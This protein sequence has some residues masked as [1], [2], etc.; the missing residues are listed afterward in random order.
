MTPGRLIG[1]ADDDD[2]LAPFG[3]GD[4]DDVGQIIFAGRIVVADLAEPA[5]QVGGAHRHHPRIAQAH[6]ALLLG[7][8]LIFDHLGD[9]VAV[10]QDDAAVFQR[11][12]RLRREHHDA[13][14]AIAVQPVD[15]PAKRLGLHERRVAIKNEDRPVVIGERALGLLDGVAGALLFGLD[16]NGHVAP[17]D[18][19]FDL[20]AS[21]A[22]H[23]HA[24]V[25]AERVDPVEQVQQH[26]PAGDRV[27][28][29]VRVGSHSG[30]L[31]SGKDHDGK[32][33][34]VAHRREQW[35]G[36]VQ[37]CASGLHKRKGRLPK[38]P[39]FRSS[40]ALCALEDAHIIFVA[41]EAHLL[42]VGLLGDGEHFIDHFV[43][44]GRVRLQVKLRN[45][46]HL[47][48]RIEILAKL[49][50]RDRRCRSTAP[51]PGR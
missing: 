37:C 36:G 18:R 19:F 16:R 13:G 22:D 46:A 39:P 26:R 44:G 9:A 24:L 43:P 42:D 4:V 7:R 14:A 25:G 48:R 3:G 21:L 32:S 27:Q 8:V 11:V 5:E 28:Y 17:G 6:R 47:L 51:D 23:D 49:R 30:A 35:H 40:S 12:G 45:R 34:L 33:A 1:I 50:H 2:R 41:D 31:P 20:V 38:G 10:A 15:H 29:L